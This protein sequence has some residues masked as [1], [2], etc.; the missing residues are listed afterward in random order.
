MISISMIRSAHPAGAATTFAQD[1]LAT[2]AFISRVYLDT[3][4]DQAE[5][6]FALLDAHD[7]R[8]TD[9]EIALARAYGIVMP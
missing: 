3:L 9:A 8:L 2:E 1:I 7:G 5:A 4:H 6:Y